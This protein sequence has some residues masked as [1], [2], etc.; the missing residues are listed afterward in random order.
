MVYMPSVISPT[1]KI[2][3][4]YFLKGGKKCKQF[5]N[6]VIIKKRFIIK[7]MADFGFLIP[8]HDKYPEIVILHWLFD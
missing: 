6:D 1:L 5:G 7:K 4:P 3:E 8:C 2:H